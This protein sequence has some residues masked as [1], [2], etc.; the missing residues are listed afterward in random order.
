MQDV[1]FSSRSG[2]A[3]DAVSEIERLWAREAAVAAARADV[4]LSPERSLEWLLL[5]DLARHESAGRRPDVAAMTA[6]LGLPRTTVRRGLDRL[7]QKNAVVLTRCPHDARRRLVSSGAGF[8]A[9]FRPLF[10]QAISQTATRTTPPPLSLSLRTLLDACGDAALVTDAPEPGAPPTV[11]GVNAA[12]QA[13]TGHPAEAMLGRS[14]AMLQGVGTDPAARRRIRRAIDT[15]RGESA[16]LVNYRRDGG[17]YLCH[18][19]IS[20]LTDETGRP[21]YFLGLARDVTYA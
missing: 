15:R 19:T 8:D 21:A 11:L 7:A 13:L 20:P 3:S 1:F 5:L 4:G 9:L 16:T 18:L 12:F 2:E 14:P 6:Q 10:R 17:S